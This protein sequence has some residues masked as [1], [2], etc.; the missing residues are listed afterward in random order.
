MD[1]FGHYWTFVPESPHIPVYIYV[2]PPEYRP[3]RRTTQVRFYLQISG[4]RNRTVLTASLD[5]TQ[6]VGGSNTPS[7]ID[8]N[9][10]QTGA[11][12]FGPPV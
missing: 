3:V 4:L 2:Y 8:S 12:A 11:F 7:F 9:L 10:L 5:R 6:E 1:Y